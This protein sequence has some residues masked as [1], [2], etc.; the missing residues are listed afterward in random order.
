MILKIKRK[1]DIVVISNV[2]LGTEEAD[3]KKLLNYLNSISPKHLV[4]NGDIIDFSGLNNQ[5][6]PK[7]HLKIIKKLIKFTSNGTKI[8]YVIGNCDKQLKKFV[9]QQI[10]SISIVN[11]LLLD[12]DGKKTWVLGDNMLGSTLKHTKWISKFGR[13]SFEMLSITNRLNRLSLRLFKQSQVLKSE[14]PNKSNNYIKEIITNHAIANGYDYVISKF[15]HEPLIV[16]ST[17][18]KESTIH[19]SSGNW[20]THFT[21]LEY[22]LKRWKSYKYAE[23]KLIPFVPDEDL[24][25]VNVKDL[26]AA[27]TIVK[28]PEE[29]E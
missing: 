20:S 18:Q 8:S 28:L 19:M 21:A 4:L 6:L 13:F 15:T 24:E 7:S 25:D 23:D 1:L 29:E 5:Q 26:I 14:K 9:G 22:R 16:Q 11:K 10:G 2:H 3:V 12:L 17:S 27:I